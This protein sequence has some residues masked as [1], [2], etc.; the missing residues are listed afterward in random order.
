MSMI[1]KVQSGFGIDD[2]NKKSNPFGSDSDE[3][4]GAL[5]EEIS[6]Q[7]DVVLGDE[8]DTTPVSLNSGIAPS[9][10]AKP[11]VIDASDPFS[12]ISQLQIQLQNQL[13]R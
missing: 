2:S 13:K 6:G 8:S 3:D 5:L 4:F 10:A 7:I 1:N 9:T 11:P 12:A